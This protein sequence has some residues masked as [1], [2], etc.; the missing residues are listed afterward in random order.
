MEDPE[1][2]FIE[3]V[4]GLFAHRPA[5]LRWPAGGDEMPFSQSVK[6]AAYRRAGGRCECARLNCG[7]RGRCNRLLTRWHA[8]HKLS[9]AAG[10]AHSLN[11]CEA[12]CVPCHQRTR[13]F[14]GY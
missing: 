6:N 11:N 10:G 13:S 3:R 7:H 1:R 4:I 14:E 2:D 8:H 12:L 5:V 9:Q